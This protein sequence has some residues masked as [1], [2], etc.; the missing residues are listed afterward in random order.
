MS[1]ILKLA[2]FT[3]I[4]H[5][6]YIRKTFA[7]SIN[8][9]LDEEDMERYLWN[10]Q[11]YSQA[12]VTHM[13]AKLYKINERIRTRHGLFGEGFQLF[14]LTYGIPIISFGEPLRR[15]MK[16]VCYTIRFM[17]ADSSEVRNSMFSSRVF[18]I[19]VG[20]GK[21]VDQ[22]PGIILPRRLIGSQTYI[23][24]FSFPAVV[25]D[26]NHVLCPG[27]GSKSYS[28]E[29]MNLL[30]RAIL[31]YGIVNAKPRFKND[32]KAAY[33]A[34]KIRGILKDKFSEFDY[35]EYY[36]E[37]VLAFFNQNTVG[38]S[39]PNN[40]EISGFT[41]TQLKA[42]DPTLFKLISQIHS[43]PNHH[44]IDRCSSLAMALRQKLSMDCPVEPSEVIC[45]DFNDACSF[46]AKMNVCTDFQWTSFIDS[47][48]ALSCGKCHLIATVSS[49]QKQTSNKAMQARIPEENI[50]TE[51]R[52]EDLNDSCSYVISNGLCY[53]ENWYPWTNENCRRTCGLC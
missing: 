19:V 2:I 41:K 53:A 1:W 7:N 22:I 21:S 10:S 25:V 37:G 52:D 29:F 49:V 23:G 3:L 27:M 8:F 46:L 26:R 38:Y 20:K 13:C 9:Q 48:C 35:Q 14:T 6:S 30:S 44:Y 47:Q 42:T 12:P 4:F 31:K 45:E 51:C 43:C 34:A 32:L 33:N 40:E 17:L 15:T 16:R 39:G 24:S 28:D 5:E 11:S 36:A 50:T 18:F